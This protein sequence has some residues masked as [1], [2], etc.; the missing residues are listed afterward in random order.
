[1]FHSTITVVS[2]IVEFIQQRILQH[3]IFT[4]SDSSCSLPKHTDY[5]CLKMQ[6]LVRAKEEEIRTRDELVLQFNRGQIVQV[7]IRCNGSD[8]GREKNVVVLCSQHDKFIEMLKYL[9]TAYDSWFQKEEPLKDIE[10]WLLFKN[11]IKS[12]LF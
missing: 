1:M 12:Y 4:I 8:L 11:S 10:V 9:E 2:S 5:R 3:V 7:C 6:G